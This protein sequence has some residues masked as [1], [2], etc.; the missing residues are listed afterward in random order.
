MFADRLREKLVDSD[1]LDPLLDGSRMVAIHDDVVEAALKLLEDTDDNKMN[2]VSQYTCWPDYDTWLEFQLDGCDIGL[3]FHG[4]ENSVLSGHA[5]F[6]LD[7]R[8]GEEIQFVPVS[9]DLHKYEMRFCD[10]NMMARMKA[11]RM[12]IDQKTRELFGLL[13]PGPHGGGDPLVQQSRMA[14]F[15]KEMKP[16]LL[17][18]LAFMNSPKLIRTREVDVARFNARRLK[19]GK[20]PYHPHHEVRLNIDKHALKITQGQGD[21]P[22]RCLHFVRAHMRFLVHQRYKNVSVVMVPPHYRGN[23]ELGIMNTSYTVDRKNSKWRN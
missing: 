16:L 17:T 7:H 10:L 18:L 20:Y 4:D 21:G 23:P 13:E 12:G 11:E 3:Y 14:P 15:V 8:D 5:L 22:E 19:R 2:K 6:M 9:I 1:L